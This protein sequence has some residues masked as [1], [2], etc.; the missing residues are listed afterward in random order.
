MREMGC[1][2]GAVNWSEAMEYPSNG[3][4]IPI[5]GGGK[6]N[7]GVASVEDMEGPE[8]DEYIDGCVGGAWAEEFIG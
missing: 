5:T 7:C 6:E 8:T 3:S 4:A 2:G 1:R